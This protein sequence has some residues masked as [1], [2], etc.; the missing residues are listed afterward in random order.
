[1]QTI[2]FVDNPQIL[3]VTYNYDYKVEINLTIHVFQVE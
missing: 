2:L 3:I 1:M